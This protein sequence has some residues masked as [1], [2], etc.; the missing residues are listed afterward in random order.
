MNYSNNK[1][2]GRK[3]VK[4]SKPINPKYK[5]LLM[6]LAVFFTIGFVIGCFVCCFTIS[7]LTKEEPVKEEVEIQTEAAKPEVVDTTEA[8]TTEEVDDFIPLDIPLSEDLQKYI[9]D[10]CCENDMEYSFVIAVIEKESTFRPSVISQTNDYGLMQ[11]NKMNHSR[12]TDAIGVTDFL[13]PYQNTAAGIYML[14]ELFDKYED[15]EKVLM[16]YNMGEGGASKLWKQGI[17]K[18]SYTNK[19]MNYAANYEQQISEK[20]GGLDVQG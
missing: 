19:V 20:E 15:P 6:I 8:E 12:L 7:Q 13:D 11:I 4:D 14:D 10:L 17:Y 18:T 9:Y 2:Y 5:R 3:V 16:A 1:T